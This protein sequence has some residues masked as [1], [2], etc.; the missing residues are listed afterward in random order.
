MQTGNFDDKDIL[1]AMFCHLAVLIYLCGE[2]SKKGCK[3]VCPFERKENWISVNAF[4]Y[5]NSKVCKRLPKM[6]PIGK[7]ITKMYKYLFKLPYSA[8]KM[9]LRASCLISICMHL[10][11]VAHFFHKN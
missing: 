7:K 11:S 2:V 10:C 1:G 8:Q 9:L 6:L 3:G 5:F 4:L